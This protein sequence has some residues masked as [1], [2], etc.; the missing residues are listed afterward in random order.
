MNQR[1]LYQNQDAQHLI[2]GKS[3]SWVG[4]LFAVLAS[5]AQ[6]SDKSFQ[7]RQAKSQLYGKAKSS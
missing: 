5:G 7:E 1:P 4:S 2:Y 6:Y 3:V